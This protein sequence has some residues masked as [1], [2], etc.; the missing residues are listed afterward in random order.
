MM[1]ASATLKQFLEF[2]SWNCG[3][4]PM[5]REGIRIAQQKTSFLMYRGRRIASP[6]ESHSSW[7]RNNIHFASLFKPFGACF[8]TNPTRWLACNEATQHFNET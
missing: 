8:L 7:T 6:C 2:E 4:G 3:L 5:E 1:A